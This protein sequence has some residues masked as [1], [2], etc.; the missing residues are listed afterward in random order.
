MAA[1]ATLT[2]NLT[3]AMQTYYDQMFLDYFKETVVMYQMGQQKRIPRNKGKVISFFR[4]HPYDIVTSVGTEGDKANTAVATTAMNLTATL[5]IYKNHTELSELL[6]L[7]MIDENLEGIVELMGQN[8][9][10][11]IDWAINVEVATYGATYVR[12]D[13]NA[14]YQFE[15]TCGGIGVTTTTMHS[16]LFT[17]S[18]DVWIGSVIAFDNKPLYGESR[19]ISDSAASGDIV[20]W[21]TAVNANASDNESQK[22]WI[23]QFREPLTA[24]DD[25]RVSWGITAKAV[26]FAVMML[27][28]R[29]AKTFSDGFFHGVVDPVVEFELVSDTEV[30]T[31]MQHSRP[32]KLETNQIGEY[33]GAMWYRTTM[34]MRLEDER[35]TAFANAT[36]TNRTGGKI[37]VTY[38]FGKNAFGVV[39][40]DGR[41][42][43]IYV[44]TPGPNTVSVPLDDYCTVGWKS[45]FV[46]KALNC[47]YCI[48]IVTY[49]E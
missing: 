25:R 16:S 9:G 27:R 40:L 10:E 37:F 24:T 6:K 14:S 21:E 41:L 45:F 1:A 36:H 8:A 39:E 2:T 32:R 28:K 38:I 19:V 5:R 3:A 29:G 35:G 48:A 23:C 47:N 12:S 4:Y 13:F 33:G 22:G 42:K 30:L 7:V 11:S 20:T 18:D 43:K 31:Y 44:K 26:R 49:Q 17:G 15:F 46:P 34:P